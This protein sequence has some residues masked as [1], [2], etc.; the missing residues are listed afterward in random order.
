MPSGAAWSGCE[1]NGK[2]SWPIPTAYRQEQIA[3]KLPEDFDELPEE[4]QQEIIAQLE[5]VVA[6]VDPAALRE[7]ILQLSKLIDQAQLLEAREIESKLVKLK[8][9][10]TEHRSSTIPKMKLLI[11][12][13]HKDT[14]DYLVGKAARDWRLTVTQIHGSA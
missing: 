12:T 6:S 13:E 10:L 7:E 1:R 2:R 3:K 4:E 9:V 8:E 14:L 5:D 11:F